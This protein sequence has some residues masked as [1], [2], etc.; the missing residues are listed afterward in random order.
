MKLY[1]RYFSEVDF[2]DR[3]LNE[4]HVIK[5]DH[6]NIKEMAFIPSDGLYFAFYKDDVR[7]LNTYEEIGGQEVLKDE[8]KDLYIINENDLK[9]VHN[10]DKLWKILSEYVLHLNIKTFE[11]ALYDYNKYIAEDEKDY[12][13][14]TEINKVLSYI[15]TNFYPAKDW[16]EFVESV[17]MWDGSNNNTLLLSGNV[18][19]YVEIPKSNRLRFQIKEELDYKDYGTYY[20]KLAYMKDGSKMIITTS[21][22]Q[23]QVGSTYTEVEN[24]INSLDEASMYL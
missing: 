15:I 7:K 1:T 22:M 21:K 8:V 19:H 13:Y 17:T 6:N 12:I 23:G 16:L 4:E 20:R 3:G 24:D 11:D 2:D 10:G 18:S 9:N 5:I 14:M